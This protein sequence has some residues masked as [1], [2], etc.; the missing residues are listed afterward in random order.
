MPS[1]DKKLD[2]LYPVCGTKTWFND[3]EKQSKS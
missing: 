3:F 2:A 1:I